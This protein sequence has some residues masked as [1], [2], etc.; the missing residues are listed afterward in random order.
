[1]RRKRIHNSSFLISPNEE[2]AE[3]EVLRNVR[4]LAK[5]EVILNSCKSAGFTLFEMIIA[6]GL[7]SVC[8]LIILSSLLSITDAQRKAVSLQTTEDNLR[9]VIDAMSKEIRTGYEYD[10]GNTGGKANCGTGG[11]SIMA[12]N[13]ARADIDKSIYRLNTVDESIEKSTDGGTVFYPLT[14]KDV[15]IKRLTFLVTGAYSNDNIHP[16]V[17][18]IIQAET[19]DRERY[20]SVFNVQTTIV[21]R[22]IDS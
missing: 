13:P 14:G 21:Q 12:F 11:R 22:Q 8:M 5:H 17:T 20:K 1:M 15:K 9:F 7:F 6:L 16:Q 19:G 10:C 2:Y 18:I 4:V 3:G